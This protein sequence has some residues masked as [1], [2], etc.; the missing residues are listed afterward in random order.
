MTTPDTTQLRVGLDQFAD[1]ASQ[2]TDDNVG[3]AT[4]CPKW[5]VGELVDHVTTSTTNFANGVRGEE[6]DW[7]AA[8][9]SADDD[10]AEVFRGRADDLLA[11][12]AAAGDTS[13]GPGQEW[14]LAELAVHT[15]DLATALGASTAGLDQQ[16]AEAGLAF[17][18]AN[19]KDEMRSEAFGPRLDAPDDADAYGRLAAFAG[20]QV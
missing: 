15:W 10:R 2:V 6:V 20:R 13:D 12:W 14:Q 16:A 1:L 8:P 18:Q 7:S 17:M 3:N 5:T 9:T 11:A 4:P 19:L